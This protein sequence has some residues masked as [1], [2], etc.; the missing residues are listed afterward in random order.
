MDLQLVGKAFV[1]VAGT[2]GMGLA[3]AKALA[4]DGAERRSSPRPTGLPLLA[5]GDPTRHL[6]C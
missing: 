6:R 3:G 5:D 1:V 2:A 4:A